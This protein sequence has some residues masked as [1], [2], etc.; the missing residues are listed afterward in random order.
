MTSEAPTRL[1]G[2][3]SAPNQSSINY[4]GHIY[5]ERRYMILFYTLLVT[6][7]ASPL[8][9]TFGMSG[10]LVESLLAICLLAAVL[11]IVER[12][13]KTAL[14]IVMAIAWLARPL[15][16]WLGLET[17]SM[18]TL[19]V[20]T[21]IGLLAAA[22]ALRFA[23]RGAKIQAEHLF[24]ALSA[25][26]LSGIYFGLLYWT[27]A[28]IRPGMFSEANLSRSGAIYF[29]FVTLATVGY[30]DIVPRLDAARGLAVVEGVG[31]QLFLAVLVARLVSSYSSVGKE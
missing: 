30:G 22:A 15:T 4:Y 16:A 21:L 12:K 11:P 13:H 2:L 7:V 25:Y 1:Q 26:L 9:A 14:L 10:T 17:L 31:G 27:L 29:S 8:L 19:G 18:V 23:L 6:M 20:W 28:Q 3:K 24:A 5:L